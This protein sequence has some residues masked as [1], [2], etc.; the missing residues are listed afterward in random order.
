MT[1]VSEPLAVNRETNVDI[2]PNGDNTKPVRVSIHSET[3]AQLPS[4]QSKVKKTNDK[5]TEKSGNCLTF[6]AYIESPLIKAL[7]TYKV[8]FAE[9]LDAV[10]HDYETL[11][12]S[13]RNAKSAIRLS[14]YLA[15]DHERVKMGRLEWFMSLG[16]A[17]ID[18][19]KD[20]YR[21]RDQIEQAIARLGDKGSG[22]LSV[23]D[24][25]KE[26]WRWARGGDKESLE[27]IRNL[28]NGGRPYLKKST[29]CRRV[30]GS[31]RLRH[32]PVN[33]QRKRSMKTDSTT[34]SHSS[35]RYPS[36][37]AAAM[38]AGGVV[39]SSFTAA[40]AD[41]SDTTASPA[42]STSGTAS[43]PLPEFS[44]KNGTH[45]KRTQVCDNNIDCA[46]GEDELP[47]ECITHCEKTDR[48]LCKD[49]LG[50]IDKR[51]QC[52]GDIDCPDGSDEFRPE[53]PCLSD[54]FRCKDNSKCIKDSEVCNGR[55]NCKDSSDES[56][57]ACFTGFLGSLKRKLWSGQFNAN[58]VIKTCCE[59][60]ESLPD[61]AIAAGHGM[62]V[63]TCSNVSEE[64]NKL[65]LSGD[66]CGYICDDREPDYQFYACEAHEE[67]QY[68]H[69]HG[70]CFEHNDQRI[71]DSY[72]H[73]KEGQDEWPAMCHIKCN[74]YEFSCDGYCHHVSVL[75][76][77]EYKT[78]RC[79]HAIDRNPKF[80][81]A[82]RIRSDRT[83]TC[84]TQNQLPM[85]D[86]L[87]NLTQ[88]CC[89]LAKSYPSNISH[90]THAL[91]GNAGASAIMTYPSTLIG[92]A[93]GFA[94][95]LAVA[96]VFVGAGWLMVKVYQRLKGTN[97][98][99]DETSS[100]RRMPDPNES[101]CFADD[102]GEQQTGEGVEN[103]AMSTEQG[104]SSGLVSLSVQ[105]SEVVRDDSPA[106][107][108]ET[109]I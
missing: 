73:C 45:I 49:G 7:R 75:C 92:S 27:L 33:L 91:S 78:P 50:C 11:T 85:S 1:I 74:W 65:R 12:I 62:E 44:C 82:E 37:K 53:C 81:T 95:G 109:R 34:R 54:E 21:R 4:A 80:C 67:E 70:I 47:N 19:K 99:T 20:V 28:V 3:V 79:A 42:S 71:C 17:G 94:I 102:L 100:F 22:N 14:S 55:K 9:V 98:S 96:G 108:I 84:E 89:Q 66:E 60:K 76:N 41:T 106:F 10:K 88:T 6:N 97:P 18:G 101:I 26:I 32:T 5:Q 40:A 86:C 93:I 72:W 35:S 77:D 64:L 107:Q 25:L 83:R 87:Q 59:Q 13:K 56:W 103:P 8:P 38:L 68:F 39:M 63:V 105:E 57:L 30:V 90:E 31:K 29:E 51:W 104:E 36:T 16:A 58:H 2:E 61:A 46:Q 23:E 24:A 48:F 15:S 43:V 69:P 52:D